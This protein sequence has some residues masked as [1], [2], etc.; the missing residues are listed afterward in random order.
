MKVC[1]L[2]TSDIGAST[3]HFVYRSGRGHLGRSQFKASNSQKSCPSLTNVFCLYYL[4]TGERDRTCTKTVDCTDNDK[5]VDLQS[6][7]LATFEDS[8]T[9]NGQGRKQ[10]R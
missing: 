8:V 5:R 3:G 9:K 2:H 4:T 6:G 7:T 1:F 10:G